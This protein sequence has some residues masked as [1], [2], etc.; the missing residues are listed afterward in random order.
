MNSNLCVCVCVRASLFVALRST[1]QGRGR[2]DFAA[3][4]LS[5]DASHRSQVQA[6]QVGPDR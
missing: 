2:G 4:R 1:V 5:G 3:L 6:A